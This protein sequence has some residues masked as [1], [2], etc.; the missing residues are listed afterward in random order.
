MMDSNMASVFCWVN[1]NGIINANGICRTT[2]TL[3]TADT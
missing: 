2:L 3:I 1:L